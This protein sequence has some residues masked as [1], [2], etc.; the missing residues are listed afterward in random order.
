[1]VLRGLIAAGV[2]AGLVP[3]LTAL[4]APPAT[5]QAAAETTP[6]ESREFHYAVALP[7]GCRH[8]EG[9]GTVD[10]ICA[11]DFDPA[12]SARASRA[13]ALVLSVAA[14]PTGGEGDASIGALQE[15]YSEAAFKEELPEAVCGES[16]KTRVKIEN[17]SEIVDGPRLVYTAEVV[18][19]PVRFLQIG[20]RRAAVRYVLAPDL[21]YRLTARAQEED[22]DKQRGTIDAFLASFRVLPGEKP[23]K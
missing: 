16:D 15:R 13:A 17:F 19:A 12:K 7:A 3:G 21:R 10:T 6:F 20:E 14:E 5:A 4:A 8:E 23:E 18:C 1:M 9:P 2:A 11:P 22:F